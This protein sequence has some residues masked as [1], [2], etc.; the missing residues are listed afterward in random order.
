MKRVPALVAAAVGVAFMGGAL[1][2]GVVR[3]ETNVESTIEVAVEGA[4]LETAITVK[5]TAQLKDGMKL[6]VVL[7]HKGTKFEERLTTV[8]IQQFVAKFGPWKRLLFP[9]QYEA[10][11]VVP[12]SI[13][14]EEL[15]KEAE[16]CKLTR[17]RV[18]FSVGSASDVQYREY[19]V[20]AKMLDVLENLRLGYLDLAQA[21]TYYR[22]DLELLNLNSRIKATEE[23]H[24]DHMKRY[25]RRK[26]EIFPAWLETSRANW[27]ERFKTTR[28]DWR[29]FRSQIVVSPFPDVDVKLEELFKL[30]ER[31]YK[32]LATQIYSLC[33]QPLPRELEQAD[34]ASD[35]FKLG[36]PI[37]ATA[38]TCYK[39]LGYPAGPE[40]RLSD[41]SVAEK[42]ELKDGVWRSYVSKFEI[43]K[44]DE[45][46]FYPGGNKPS[47]RLTFKPPEA[48]DAKAPSMTVIAAEIL[49]FATAENMKHLAQLARE[50]N[51][52]RWRGAKEIKSENVNAPD[53]TMPGGV[54]PG[55]ESD[56]QVDDGKRRL[57]IRYYQL[58]C[59]WHKR[60][61]GVLCIAPEDEFASREEVFR[62]TC[63][64]F[65]VLDAPEFKDLKE[66]ERRRQILLEGRDPDK[67][68][69]EGQ[70]GD[71]QKP[72]PK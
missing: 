46:L 59:R 54:R 27:D 19:S 20:K 63:A 42:G 48:K 10:Q 6:V 3:S 30:Y 60:T 12:A 31:W 16:G 61:Y 44:P 38:L 56:F 33:G 57:H 47:I 51:R 71:T 66:D 49:D 25:A 36:P 65:K 67:A 69:H 23:I 28:Y 5:G 53:R 41:L 50:L 13:Q 21:G 29:T 37:E 1:A 11:V 45:W 8:G 34:V 39:G 52:N 68:L 2:P 22:A 62:K 15:K 58:F 43:R 18:S 17:D 14:K 72:P 4:D 9:G 7:L 64:S 55:M 70:Q 32:G 24:L 35:P 26:L 40:W